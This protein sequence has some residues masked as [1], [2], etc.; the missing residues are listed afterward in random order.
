MRRV[1]RFLRTRGRHAGVVW[2]DARGFRPTFVRVGVCLSVGR[3]RRVE[4]RE[5]KD[6][7]AGRFRV[8]ARSW[9]P[10]SLNRY[11]SLR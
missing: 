11:L 7:R 10:I 3:S 6:A 8:S 1:G 9:S 2:Q 4:E 5:K